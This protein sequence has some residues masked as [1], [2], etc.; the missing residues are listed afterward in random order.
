MKNKQSKQKEFTIP[1]HILLKKILETNRGNWKSTYITWLFVMIETVCET[2]V[3]FFLS[4]LIDSI[5]SLDKSKDLGVIFAYSGGI[6]ALAVVAALTGI[7]A[8]YFAAEAS[9]SFGRNLRKAIFSKI[10]DYSFENID[11]FSTSSIV[12]RSTTDLTNV[13]HSFLMVIRSVIRAPLLMIFALIMCFIIEYRLAWIFLLIIP[14][15]LF[16]LITTASRAHVVFVK[17]FNSYDK[18]NSNV[19]EDVD[20]IRAIKSFNREDSKIS[21][22]KQSSN[23]IYKNFIKAEK[24]L[25]FNAP[26]MDIAI[27][28]AFLLLSFFGANLIV[29]YNDTNFSIGS[30]TSLFNYVMMIMISMMMISTIYVM[31]IISRNSGER[32]IELLDEKPILVNCDNPVYEIKNGDIEFKNV[33]FA[34]PNK[35]NSLENISFS[36]KSGEVLGIIGP[37]GSSKTTLVSMIARLYDVKEGCV[38]VGGIDVKNYDLKTL[39]DSVSV[40]LQKNTLFSGTIRSNLSFGNEYASDEQ[41]WEALSL[42]QASDFVSSFKDGLDYKVEQGGVNFSGGQKQRLCIA[43]ALLKDPKILILDDTTS[44]CDTHTDQLIRDNLKRTK[45]D[46]TK[47]I[48]SQRVS[49]IKDCDKIIVMDRGKI[50]AEGKNDELMDSCEIYKELYESQL[51]GGDFDAQ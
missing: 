21:E 18:L 6:F 1:V 4:F 11:K 46:V 34:Y 19:Q 27:Y 40:V 23:F 32:I 51:G 48:I 50:I 29:K 30:L 35:N 22:F 16:L 25:A 31:L 13:Q 5:N 7:L 10:Q 39:R 26:V 8:G 47:I 9:S 20:G 49:S 33:S 37:T 44:A 3:T 15:V 36:L 24:I 12:T 28:L 43:R 42:A 45:P 38:K 2:L 41:M 17:I 14:F